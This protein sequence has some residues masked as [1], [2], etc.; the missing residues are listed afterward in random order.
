MT[1]NGFRVSIVA[2]ALALA[3]C[4]GGGSSDGNTTPP[5]TTTTYDLA[6][7]ISMAETAAVDSDLN[8]VNQTDR[9]SNDSPSAPQALDAPVLL[10]GT[11]NELGLGPAGPNQAAGDYDDFF[12]ADLVAGQVIELEFAAEPSSNDVDL[13]VANAD[14]SSIG[15]SAGTDTRYECVRISTTGRY[16]IDVNAFKGASIYNL[17]IGAP[18]TGGTCANSTAA[19]NFNPQELLAVPWPAGSRVQAAAVTGGVSAGS[20]A[21]LLQQG[22]VTAAPTQGLGPQL[23]Q[24]PASS[25]ARVQGLGR[26]AAATGRVQAATAA[27]AR[28]GEPAAISALRYAKQLRATGLYQDVHPNWFMQR[29][30][31]VGSFPPNDRN[32]AYQRWHYEQINLPAAM[33]RLQALPSQPATRPVVAV[34]DDGVVLNHPDLAPQLFSVGR[35]F[36]SR[37]TAGDGNLASGDNL[38]T[39][40]DN[41]VFHGTHVAGTVA[42]STFDGDFGAGVAPMAQ[43]LPL[44]V[45]PPDGGATLLDVV[46]AMLY[47]ARLANNSGTLPSRAADVINMSLG[48][49]TVCPTAYQNAVNQVRAAGV[50]VV[51]AA[52]NSARNDLGRAVGVGTPAN[53]GGVI[54]VSAL[55]ARKQLTFYS[56]TG[57]GVTVAGPG[58][59]TSQSTS[60]SGAPDGIYSSVATFDASGNRLASFGPMMGTSMASPHVAGVMALMRYVNPA[61]TPGQIDTL[62][63]SGA[64]TDD[65][66]SLGRDSSTGWGLINARK[67][68]DAAL[69]AA[70]SST[71]LP[72]GAIVATPSSLD[73]G[74]FA[75]T[76]TL[77]LS[78]TGSSG[79]RVTAITSSSA[80]V[81]VSGPAPANTSGL[82]RYTLTLNRNLLP[83]GTSYPTVTFQLQPS[84][85]LVV[86]LSVTRT[87]TGTAA[88][89]NFGPIYVVVRDPDGSDSQ[90]VLASYAAGHY[91]WQLSGWNHARAVVLSGADLDNDDFICQ[92]GEPCGVYPI[93]SAGGDAGVIDLSGNRSD[94]DMQLAP[95]GSFSAAAAGL[96]A[97]RP[98]DSA[99]GVRR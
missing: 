56:N 61:L 2:F 27:T 87:A 26:L 53:C 48:A 31:L 30:A 84:R 79:E 40:A 37:N 83:I 47:A 29:T 85:T 55:D 45:F 97:L 32:Y 71:P 8:D 60:G 72:S 42:A 88:A 35:T 24:L 89:G 74:S 82:G 54:A 20:A 33:A 13:Y 6:G 93:S 25:S 58:G 7:R 77:D 49:D 18:G 75:S 3:G 68:V 70:G 86:Q 1:R 65:L 76:A 12:A 95:V 22:G 52:G 99:A 43:I 21:A 34:I 5:P 90:T 9:V 4:G 92:R 67:A 38:S 91:Q 66:A 50:I 59:D 78:D 14:G 64:L 80:A 62:F 94:L 36:I 96:Q 39:R 57:A 63:A 51:A 15:A 16:L 17:R 28:T 81:T 69:A 23:L 11:V 19:L 46:N 44:R 73:F 10:V 41:P 98:G